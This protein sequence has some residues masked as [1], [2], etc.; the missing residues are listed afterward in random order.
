MIAMT[1]S[2][3]TLLVDVQIALS[4]SELD[5]S[6]EPPGAPELTAWANAAYAAVSDLSTE[7]TIRVVDCDEIIALN[8]DYRHKDKATNVLS[9]PFEI[10]PDIDIAL[11][12]DIVICH[13]VIATEAAQQ[14]KSVRNHYAH[15][16]T[17]G[18]LHLCGYDHQENHAANEME[19]L[20]TKILA[21]QG[22]A[23]P[24]Q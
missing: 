19:A 17:H 5:E 4:E 14:G 2:V 11:L 15:M 7:V 18:V 1:E 6:E 21:T 13:S 10:D 16:V 8:R 22:I 12:G 3:P 23:N 9:F 20:E 24:Y